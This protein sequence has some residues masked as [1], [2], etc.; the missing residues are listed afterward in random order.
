M[1]SKAFI[2]VLCVVALLNTTMSTS[3]RAQQSAPHQ[4]LS[5]TPPDPHAKLERR[6]GIGLLI[7]SAASVALGIVFVA[8]AKTSNDSALANN[9]YDP[10]AEDR[11]NAFQ[12]THA[13]FFSLG[14]A[15][16]AG[17][18]VLLWDR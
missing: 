5:L 18:M 6:V 14:A 8:L 4:A 10:S 12:V 7:G 2:M 11:R 17:G 15:S 16:F 9:V 13:V 3:V 1:T